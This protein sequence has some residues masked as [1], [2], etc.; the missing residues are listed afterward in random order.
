MNFFYTS[1]LH[2][3][4]NFYR[5]LIT[6]CRENK[7]EIL[8][9]GGDLLPRKGHSNRSISE[10]KNFI[11]DFLGEI[12]KKIKQNLKVKIFAILGNNDW[13]AVLDDIKELEKAGL[14]HILHQ[15]YFEI[16]NNLFITG[17]PFVPP[18]KFSPKDFEKRDMSDDEG[19]N[20]TT[21]PVISETGEIKIVKEE[22][23]FQNR[24]SIEDDLKE[25]REYAQHNPEKKIIYVMHSPPFGTM[26]DRL[27]NSQPAGSRAIK[28]FI[29]K[30]Q[31]L[32]T[33]HGH[34]HE[35]PAISSKYWE[36]IGSTLSVNP[37]QV[38]GFLSG[39]FFN[40]DDPRQ[41]IRHNQYDK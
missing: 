6:I 9:L 41:S 40:S 17:Y 21:F 2:G 10:Q 28:A 13:A 32:L 11:H 12:L 33:L 29:E 26:L 37:G 4:K 14:I 25:F 1:D 20:I 22:F 30:I 23:F 35:S 5:E 8:V 38:G 16:E 24:P 7:V 19:V 27:Y 3:D 39:V 18:T 15:T 34:I 31:P 36:M